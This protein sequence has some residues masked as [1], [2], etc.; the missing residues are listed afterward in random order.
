M[1]RLARIVNPGGPHHLTQGDNRRLPEFF[2][3]DDDRQSY[4]GLV[5][6]A[7]AAT[8]NNLLPVSW[9][10][11]SWEFRGHYT[12]LTARVSG[13]IDLPWPASLAS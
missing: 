5:A 9:T 4:L 2:N 3:D 13:A 12:K 7:C 8:N 10:V 6:S 1:A 11:L